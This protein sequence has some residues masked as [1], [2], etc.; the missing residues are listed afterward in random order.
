MSSKR[1]LKS[2]MH[3]RLRR[4]KS[5]IRHKIAFFKW[6]KKITGRHTIRGITHDLGKLIMF[7]L[8]FKI[9]YVRDYHKK[10]AKHHNAKTIKD[11]I[12]KL[13][14]YECARFTKRNSSLTAKEYIA[15]KYDETSTEYKTLM[16]LADFYGLEK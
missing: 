9:Q 14:D 16:F 11:Y 8:P 2:H 7:L 3:E 12:E 6:E 4:I 1:G 5:L 15:I 13:V 10:H